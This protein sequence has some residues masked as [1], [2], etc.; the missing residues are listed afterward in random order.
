MIFEPRYVAYAQ[1]TANPPNNAVMIF[2]FPRM[3]VENCAID[4]FTEAFDIDKMKL[5]SLR[6]MMGKCL[7]SINGYD[8]DPRELLEIPEVVAFYRALNKKWPYLYYFS[9]VEP[10][11]IVYTLACQDSVVSIR[12]KTTGGMAYTPTKETFQRFVD[13]SLIDMKTPWY[14]SG[15]PMNGY[16]ERCDEIYRFFRLTPAGRPS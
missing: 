3:N 12:K 1:I 10:A 4:E 2:G 6:N 9:R 14:K 7:F 8:N 11:L 15:L 5:E 13:K 16:R